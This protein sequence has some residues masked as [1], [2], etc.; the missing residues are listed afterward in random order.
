MLDTNF[1]VSGT[2][3]TKGC[4]EKHIKIILDHLK[5]LMLCQFQASNMGRNLECNSSLKLDE[6]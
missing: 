1:K 2:I 6:V 5:T 3:D 4:I